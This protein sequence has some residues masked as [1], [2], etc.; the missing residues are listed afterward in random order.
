[1]GWLGL[2]DTDHLGGGCTTKTLDLLIQGL[3]RDVDIGEIRLVRLWPFA[4]Q[5]TRGNASV[6]VEINCQDENKLLNH[7]DA[8]WDEK[9]S[10]LA[11]EISS[12]ENYDRQQYPADPGMVWFS[13]QIPSVEF[14]YN[15]VR[16]EVNIDEVPIADK[17]WGGQGRIGA[18]AAIAWDKAQVT[19]EAIAWRTEINTGTKNLLLLQSLAS[20]SISSQEMTSLCEALLDDRQQ[21]SLLL[22]IHY[23][24]RVTI[25]PLFLKHQVAVQGD[26]V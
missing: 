19:Y 8:W 15:T 2:D 3:P 13:S 14:Y 17:S 4:K 6:A 26:H 22:T 5:R 25:Q 9:I 23:V 11:G 18:T 7:L 20:Q 21:A 1:M 10:P 12:T 24:Y 16:R